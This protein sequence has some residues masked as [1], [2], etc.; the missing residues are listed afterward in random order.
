MTVSLTAAAAREAGAR[1][2]TKRR[3]LAIRLGSIVALLLAWEICGMLTPRIFLPPFHETV[4]AFWR[5]QGRD[6]D[7]AHIEL[8]VGTA[9]RPRYFGCSRSSSLAC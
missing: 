6:A 8:A 7:R 3:N 4:V 9:R 5:L 1:R 2:A